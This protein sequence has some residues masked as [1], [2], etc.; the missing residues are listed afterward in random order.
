MRAEKG[1][2]WKYSPEICN[3]YTAFV[4]LWNKPAGAECKVLSESNLQFM[5][6]MN[7]KLSHKSI[8]LRDMRRL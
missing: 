2:G 3:F 4:F 6:L 5:P 1:L 8:I 7:S